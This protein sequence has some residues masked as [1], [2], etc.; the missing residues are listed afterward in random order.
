MVFEV[1]PIFFYEDGASGI[2]DMVEIGNSGPSFMTKYPHE[3]CEHSLPDIAGA[4]G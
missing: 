1:H 3:I 2:G 4:S